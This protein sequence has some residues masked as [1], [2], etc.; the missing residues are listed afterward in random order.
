MRLQ[1]SFLFVEA[2]VSI[3]LRTINSGEI[4]HGERSDAISRPAGDH[5]AALV[6]TG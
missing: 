1:R 2:S 6:V 4:C 3:A 5:F